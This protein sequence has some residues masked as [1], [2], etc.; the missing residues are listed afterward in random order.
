MSPICSVI[1]YYANRPRDAVKLQ[2]WIEPGR[3]SHS[4]PAIKQTVDR[5]Q[6]QCPEREALGA[7]LVWKPNSDGVFGIIRFEGKLVTWRAHPCPESARGSFAQSIFRLSEQLVRH[8]DSPSLEIYPNSAFGQG[9]FITSSEICRRHCEHLWTNGQV[10][11]MNRT[12]KEAT[13][14][15][16]HYDRH[17]ELESHLDDFIKAY[18]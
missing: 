8:I 6:P 7:F 12:I 2:T 16:Y 9:L 1:C 14:K 10:E 15:R 3:C 18:N 13:V 5:R 17:E 11:R 4:H